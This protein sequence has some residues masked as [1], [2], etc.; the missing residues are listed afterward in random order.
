MVDLLQAPGL[1]LDIDP[2]PARKYLREDDASFF[3]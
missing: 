1:G 2:E 3:T